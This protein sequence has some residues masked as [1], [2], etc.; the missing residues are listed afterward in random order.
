MPKKKSVGAAIRRFELVGVDP[1]FEPVPGVRFPDG[2]VVTVR[3]GVVTIERPG[4]Y[5]R[6]AGTMGYLWIDPPPVPEGLTPGK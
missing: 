2:T 5:R 3:E 4:A 1:G 6:L